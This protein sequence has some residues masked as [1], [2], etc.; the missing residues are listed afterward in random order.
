MATEVTICNSALVS[1]GADKIT[2]LTD[3]TRQARI[4]NE[5]YESERDALL[6]EHR[7]NFAIKRVALAVEDVTPLG[8]TY[9]YALPSDY[10]AIVDV[11]GDDV[12]PYVIEGSSLLTDDSSVELQYVAHVTDPSLWSPTFCAALADRIAKKIAPK[13]KASV[14]RTESLKDDYKRSL[15]KA[16]IV[17]APSSGK[18]K[19][20][21]PSYFI[22][23]R[24]G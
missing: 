8:Y 6:A 23:A 1:V 17:D 9:S 7:W 21:R 15:L 16:K 12:G 19:S 2:S 3:G 10:L 5:I 24:G 20:K 4:C 11:L 13:M 18:P 22:D 14:S